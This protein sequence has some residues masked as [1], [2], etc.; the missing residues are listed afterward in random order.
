MT[1][2]LA[3]LIAGCEAAALAN[4]DKLARDLARI[5]P[6]SKVRVI[7]Q[8][9]LDPTTGDLQKLAKQGADSAKRFKKT[10][11]VVADLPAASL[12]GLAAAWGSSAASWR[13]N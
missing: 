2:R 4:P 6:G 10:R 9:P 11:A 3:L 5:A 13:E 7:A 12:Q 8:Y 1:S